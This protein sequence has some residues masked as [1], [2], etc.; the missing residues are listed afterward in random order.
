M[1][2]M[3]IPLFLFTVLSLVTVQSGFADSD[4]SMSSDQ[5]NRRPFKVAVDFEQTRFTGG[6]LAAD[7]KTV[8]NRSTENV[9]ITRMQ[10]N[11]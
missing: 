4:N 2:W 11:F 1:T 6:Q 3:R 9:L 7:K 8:T 5:L 10:V